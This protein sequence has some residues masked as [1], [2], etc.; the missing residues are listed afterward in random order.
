MNF[1]ALL[2]GWICC[3]LAVVGSAQ[4]KVKAGIVHYVITDVHTEQAGSEL[5]LGSELTLSFTKAKSKIELNLLDGAWK[6]ETLFDADQRV[7][8]RLIAVMGDRY[9]L[10]TP[11]PPSAVSTD[12]STRTIL[13]DEDSQREIAGYVCHK[14]IITTS[15]GDKLTAW[16]TPKIQPPTGHFSTLFMGLKGFPLE[17]SV[18]NDRVIVTFAADEVIRRIDN[19]VF[20]VVGKYE[21]VSAAEYMERV[22]MLGLGF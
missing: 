12:A 1:K 22:G 14:A 7:T 6:S 11:L 20:F 18:S 13:Y 15:N 19:S 9:R 10:Q 8:D 21:E 3:S 2:I 4:K 16:V 17:F 5:L